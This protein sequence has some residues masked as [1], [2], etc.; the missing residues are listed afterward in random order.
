MAAVDSNSDAT[1]SPRQACA[2]GSSDSASVYRA[3]IEREIVRVLGLMDR[4]RFSPTSGCMD[5]TY[6]AWKFTDFPGARFQEGLCV[7]AFLYATE[8]PNSSYWRNQNLL[9]WIGHGFDYWSRTQYR[10]GE[11]DEAYPFERSLAATAFTS[12]YLSEAWRFV[13]AE[14]PSSTADRFRAALSRGAGWLTHNDETHGFLSNHLAAA[15]AAL[16][17]AYEILGDGRFERR[18]GYFLERILSHQSSEG[19]YDEYGGADPG[20]Q[21]HGSFY[22][23]R[24]LELSGDERLVSSLE[25]SFEFL[26]HFVHPDG[27][28]GGEYASRNT[29]TYYPAA[30]EMMAGRSGKARWIADRMRPAVSTLSA[31]GLGSVD[32]YNYFPL[33]NNYV[34]AYQATTANRE[35]TMEPEPPEEGSGLKHF[36]EAGIAI[37]RSDHYRAYVGLHKGGVLKVFD[38]RSAELIL[39]D[40][41]YVGRLWD[42]KLISSQ[43]IDKSREV[44]VSADKI[45]IRGGFYGISKLVMKPW[46]FM[47]FRLFNLTLGR[48]R[49]FSYWLKS[50]LVKTLI[51]RKRDIALRFERTIE[52]AADRIVIRDRIG[53][54][55]G[56]DVATLR[57]ED[58]FTTIHMGSSRYFVPN[59]L[60][61]PPCDTL[62]DTIVEVGNLRDGVTL[63]RTALVGSAQVVKGVH[64]ADE[65]GAP[66]NAAG[67]ENHPDA[68]ADSA[69]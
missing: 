47:A 30:F 33:L 34:F 57:R 4:E 49:R 17:N 11:W 23:A 42:G 69:Q 28:L 53:G 2:D 9:R 35:P 66:G 58:V 26:A 5:R 21:T 13:G 38:E 22:L 32:A 15:A 40:C 19:W 10:G 44:S 31:A 14:L 3:A 27:S 12:F 25:R 55:A 16:L 41:G 64:V 54:A 62:M 8:L 37:V 18:A 51:Y 24:Y 65:C 52:L 39:S 29:Q 50:L 45:V 46:R 1:T 60:N 6:W 67:A 36:S 63:E 20:Y 56:D 61:T 43:W 7:L 48:V 68:G 59:E